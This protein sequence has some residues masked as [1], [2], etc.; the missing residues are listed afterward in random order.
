MNLLLHLLNLSNLLQAVK[1]STSHTDS[2][3]CLTRPQMAAPALWSRVHGQDASTHQ[4]LN[5]KTQVLKGRSEK[6]P[7]VKTHGAYIKSSQSGSNASHQQGFARCA[8]KDVLPMGTVMILQMTDRNRVQVLAP[9]LGASCRGRRGVK[10]AP[11]R[12]T[13]TCRVRDT[14]EVVG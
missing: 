5:I 6:A 4:E 3:C 12:W 1:R 11:F 10:C 7:Y 13:K 9:I 8:K 14:G 2:D